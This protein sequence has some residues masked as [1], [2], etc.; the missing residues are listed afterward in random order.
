MTL[1]LHAR[2]S[3]K[4]KPTRIGSATSTKSAPNGVTKDSSQKKP[5]L[6]SNLHFKERKNPPQRVRILSGSSSRSTPSVIELSPVP[7]TTVTPPVS[8]RRFSAGNAHPPFGKYRNSPPSHL[9]RL[10]TPNTPAKKNGRKLRGN[11]FEVVPPVKPKKAFEKKVDY[12]S[13]GDDSGNESDGEQ[14]R[15]MPHPH[16]VA[17]YPQ[18]AIVYGAP[19]PVYYPPPPKGAKGSRRYKGKKKERGYRDIY[20]D[21]KNVKRRS[22]RSP[23]VKRRS[24]R[25]PLVEDTPSDSSP[26]CV[27]DVSDDE[28]PQ[29]QYIFAGHNTYDPYG[30]QISMHFA[31][32]AMT[33][34]TSDR[35]P[36]LQ[37]YYRPTLQVCEDFLGREVDKMI[38]EI[39]RESIN[40]LA[41]DIIME[42]VECRDP[43]EDWM[44]RLIDQTV[45]QCCYD[46]VKESAIE[47]AD[48][49]LNNTYMNNIIDDVIDDIIFEVGPAVVDDAVFETLLDKFLED[50]VILPEILEES[51][52]VSKEVIQGYDDK[53]TQRELKAVTLKAEDKLADSLCLQYLL[54]TIARQGQLWSESDYSSRYLD[55]LIVNTLIEQFMNVIHDREKTLN[56]KP[57]KKLHQ[58]VVT[59]V[60]LDVLL[61][62][63]SASLDEDVADVDE[64]ERGVVDGL[65]LPVL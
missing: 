15:Y 48:E 12:D 5:I 58:K 50:E 44:N 7:K 49:H 54:S 37:E 10:E 36:S 29:Y 64:Y 18:P 41:D 24:V 39:V 45:H 21:R 60:A 65:Q 1:C 52:E 27:T 14:V 8:N 34:L 33:P 19:F 11:K 4:R 57:L 53:I 16:P 2:K 23:L 56:N 31:L 47:L 42:K 61:Q 3:G 22:R 51:K 17:F 43:V 28:R 9:L 59:D 13:W 55:N 6:K 38:R 32:P 30:E 40:T 35:T 62:K 25:Q 63:L 26:T 46:I 20:H